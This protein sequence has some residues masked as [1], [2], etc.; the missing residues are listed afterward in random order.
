M[1]ELQRSSRF[2]GSINCYGPSLGFT[3]QE[4][5]SRRGVNSK[6]FSQGAGGKTRGRVKKKKK[7][8]G[9]N[10]PKIGAGNVSRKIANDTMANNGEVQN[11]EQ[12]F[13][14]AAELFHHPQS[15]VPGVECTELSLL[16]KR[17]YFFRWREE[18]NFPSPSMLQISNTPSTVAPGSF[19]WGGD[20]A[21]QQR[22]LAHRIKRKR[23]RLTSRK[24][25]AK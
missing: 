6:P 9:L 17:A 12:P 23:K 13:L 25:A 16:P 21:V 18:S 14:L 5:E 4:S 7:R 19:G 24:P 8:D 11:T 15:G 1:R 20:P 10:P 22:G 3:V 2:V